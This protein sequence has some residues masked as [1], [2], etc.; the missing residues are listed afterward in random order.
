MQKLFRHPSYLDRL[1]RMMHTDRVKVVTGV[2]RCSKSYLVFNLFKEYLLSH[3]VAE[4]QIFEMA[5]DHYGSRRYRDPKLFYPHV[6][7]AIAG[8]G[9]HCVLLDEVQLLG[10]FEEILIELVT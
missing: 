2:R 6:N 3:G 9:Y 5:F 7:A 1:V 8:D 4:T 10:H